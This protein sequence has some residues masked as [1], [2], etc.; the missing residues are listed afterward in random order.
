MSTLH[1][2]GMSEADHLA[3]AVEN[4]ANDLSGQLQTVLENREH[5][6]SHVKVFANVL[7]RLSDSLEALGAEMHKFRTETQD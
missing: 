3:L 6:Y 2:S 5:A 7:K 4:W 1:D